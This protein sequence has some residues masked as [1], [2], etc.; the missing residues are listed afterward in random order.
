MIAAL[1]LVLVVFGLVA[2]TDSQTA[3]R[4]PVWVQWAGSI[5]LGM[6]ILIGVFVRWR[7][8]LRPL[9]ATSHS[10]VEH[11]RSWHALLG[12]REAPATPGLAERASG[13]TQRDLAVSRLLMS[14][15]R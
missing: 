9:C 6:A 13:A 11:T 10:S 3:R 12:S 2:V 7:A 8:M 14:L 1:I 5:C 15:W 4:F